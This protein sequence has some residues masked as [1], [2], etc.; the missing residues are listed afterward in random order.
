MWHVS[1]LVTQVNDI[2]SRYI[3]VHNAIF[4]FSIRKLLP[5]PGLFKAIDY[6]SHYQAL[7]N[8]HSE[9]AQ[10]L[11]AIA[12]VRASEPAST[13]TGA[14]LAALAEYGSALSDTIGSLRDMCSHLYRKSQGATDYSWATYER[15]NDAYMASVLRYMALGE[16]LN[17]LWARL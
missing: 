2:L 13:N 16:H 10:T 11:E 15:D 5:I 14:F 1:S 9:L 12:Q 8:L 7:D 6:G 4:K 17:S 3:L